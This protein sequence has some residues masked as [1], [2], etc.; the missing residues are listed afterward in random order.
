M[1]SPKGSTMERSSVIKNIW[2]FVSGVEFA[3]IE[4]QF[5]IYFNFSFRKLPYNSTYLRI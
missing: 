4:I 1:G 2:Q 5:P 3:L